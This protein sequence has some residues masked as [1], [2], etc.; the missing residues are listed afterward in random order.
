MSNN[1]NGYKELENVAVIEENG[2]VAIIESSE[3]IR[4]NDE[5]SFISHLDG[6]KN[7]ATVLEELGDNKYKIYVAMSEI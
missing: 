4:V 2:T 3:C 7:W 6:S 5:I 1:N